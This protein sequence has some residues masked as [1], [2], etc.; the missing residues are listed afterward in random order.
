[1]NDWRD[2]QSIKESPK[3]GMSEKET[4]TPTGKEKKLSLSVVLRHVHALRFDDASGH[5]DETKD[6]AA[7]S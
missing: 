1:M 3:M 4:T 2:A 7:D 6:E 5:A